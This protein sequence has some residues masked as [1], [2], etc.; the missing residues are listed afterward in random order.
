MAA[1]ISLSGKKGASLYTD[2]SRSKLN[3]NE[4]KTSGYSNKDYGTAGY[5]NTNTSHADASHKVFA[6]DC[7]MVE[8][9][10]GSELAHVTVIDDHLVVVYKT[11]VK[12]D[13][14]IIDY[15]TGSTGLTKECMA[16]ASTRLVDVQAKLLGMI[17]GSTILIGHALEHDLR[18]LKLIHGTVVDTSIVFKHPN[19]PQNQS[20]KYSLKELTRRV[21]HRDIQL[22][23]HDSEE[24]AVASFQLMLWKIQNGKSAF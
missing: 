11:L 14:P 7:E 1:K 4:L 10:A 8:T 22:G 15:R 5:V 9:Q 2:M 3:E 21:L 16:G 23:Q 12:P 6:I 13:H 24:D 17:N 20:N 19:Y 18:A